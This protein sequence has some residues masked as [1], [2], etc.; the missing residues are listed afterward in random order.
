MRPFLVLVI[1][2]LTLG[3]VKA[4]TMFQ[5][6]LP[7]PQVVQ[8]IVHAAEGKFS[9]DVTLTFDAHADPF[10]FPNASVIIRLGK[11]ES[12]KNAREI[13]RSTETIKAGTPIL[14][15]DVA[16]LQ[17]GYNPFEVD[18]F[19]GDEELDLH[20]AVRVRVLRDGIPIVEETIWSAPG[21]PVRESI[22][23]HVPRKVRPT[24]T[25]QH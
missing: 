6:S 10:V 24:E 5:S 16:E 15:D 23:I 8:P 21:E 1:G 25:H 3:S 20:H 22:G 18:V 9:V 17:E 19:P 4:F 11:D 14:I 12:G 13:F 7:A 2:A